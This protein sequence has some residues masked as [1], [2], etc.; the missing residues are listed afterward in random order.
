MKKSTPIALAAILAASVASADMASY[1][2]LEYIETTGAQYI[3][4]GLYPSRTLR[5]V[6]TLSTTDT[7][8]DKM[9]FGVRNAGYAFLCWLGKNPGTK[10]Y[11]AI[12]TSGNIANRNS[13]KT[14]GEKWT[15]DMGAN[16]LYVDGT[17]IF[18]AEEFANYTSTATVSSKT[19]LLFGLSNNG[20]V[21][22]RKYV[23]KCYSFKA[24]DGG[25]L[26]RDLVPARRKSDSVVGLYDRANDV[27]YVNK[28]SGSF[29]AGPLLASSLMVEGSP[30]AVGAV[31]P[32]YGS[33]ANTMITDV[34]TNCSA[35]ATVT[36]EGLTASCAGYRFYRQTGLS[37]WTLES[38][39][40]GNTFTFTPNSQDAR[41]VWLW[42]IVADLA[43]AFDGAPVP[44]LNAI[45]FP[46]SVGGLGASGAPAD[47]KAAWGYVADDLAYT[48]TIATI[49]QIGATSVTLPRLHPG[50]AFFVKLIL[51]SQAA[52]GGSV[53]TGV[54]CVET[55][56]LDENPLIPGLWQTFFTSADKN[57]T[58]DIWAVPEGTDWKNYSDANRIRR[59]E[60][61]VI[62]PYTHGAAPSS[63]TKYLSEVWGDEVWWPVNGGQ[64]AYAGYIWLDAAKS[65][66]F[67][68]KIDDNERIQIT[69]ARTGVTTTLINDTGNGNG[70]NT[71]PV[72]TPSVTGWHAIEL[73][74]SDGSGGLGGYDSAN[75]YV[76][77]S[78]LGFSQD[79][80]A[81]WN[82]L[83]DPGN[84]SLLRAE[85]GD[86]SIFA[87]EMM[88]NGALASVSLDFE[89]DGSANR[90][91]MAAW[92]KVVGGDN[93][94]DWACTGIVATVSATDTNYVWTVPADWGSDSNLVV[95]FYFD[96][97]TVKWS[98]T[99]LWRDYAAPNVTDVVP[100]GTGGDTLVISG[101]LV[102][103]SGQD[104][105][106][107]VHVGESPSTMT[108][109]WT[110]LAGSVRNATG[111]FALT[112][113]ESD[114]A[115]PMYLVPGGTY[116]VAVEA[117]AGGRSSRTATQAVTM[118]AAPVFTASPAAVARRTITFSGVLSD[119]G[120][121]DRATLQLYVGAASDAEE[122]LV[123][124]EEPV[125][126]TGAM[127]FAIAHTFPEFETTYKWQLR[128]VAKAAGETATL[129]TRSPVQTCQ[130]L[131]TTTY[132]WKS[133]VASGAWDDASN[134]TDNQS[135]DCLGYPQ[136]AA[137][138][139]TFPQS[140]GTEV[141]F[142][143]ALS[144]GT[145]QVNASANVTFTQGGA[146]TN[147][148][149][150]TVTTLNLNYEKGSLTLDG[151]AVNAAND[152]TLGLRRALRAINGADLY[153]RNFVQTG[154]N[155]V[156]VAGESVL[157]CNDM[158]F[159]GGTF[160]ISNATVNVRAW[161]YLGDS[162]P[163]GHIVFR[164]DH[165]LFR[166]SNSAGVIYASLAT[167]AVQFD[168]CVPAG[169]YAAAP[170]G[171]SVA[172]T[173]YLGNNKGSAGA[174]SYTVNVLDDSPANF[175]D[176]PVTATLISWPYGINTALVNEGHLPEDN[177]AATDDAFVWG[178]GTYPPTLSVAINGSSHAGEL[179]VSCL[180]AHVDC[181]LLSPSRG[182]HEIAHG[183]LINCSAPADYIML[184]PS[185]RAICVGWK[186]YDIDNA[187]LSRTLAASG[188]NTSC[189]VSDT[190]LWRELE[191]QWRIEHLITAAAGA[192]GSVNPASQWVG[193]GTYAVVTATPDAT[194]GFH[195]WTDGVPPGCQAV[196]ETLHFLVTGPVVVG[197]SFGGVYY[198]SPT[199]DATAPTA[200][201]ATG[202]R[203]IQAAL[204]V[205]RDGDTVLVDAGDYA[206]EDAVSITH[207]VKVIGAGAGLT[208]IFKRGSAE[209]SYRLAYLNHADAVLRGMS[210][211]NG[212]AKGLTGS[213][214]YIDTAGGRV[215]DCYIANNRCNYVMSSAGS[216]SRC[217]F[218][219][220][221]G[222]YNYPVYVKDG[223]IENCLSIRNNV[224]SGNVP[225]VGLR[226]EGKATARNCTVVR[227]S[228]TSTTIGGVCCAAATVRVV[229][230]VIY[231]NTA[232]SS[233]AVGAPDWS[234]DI[235]CFVNCAMQVAPNASCHGGD[236]GFIDAAASNYRLLVGSALRNAGAELADIGALDL[237]GGARISGGA[238][239]I[240]CYEYDESVAAVGLSIAPES[241][242]A[243]D[244]VVFTPAL[245]GIAD[246][247]ART[248]TITDEHGV[249]TV[250]PASCES[251]AVLSTPGLYTVRLDVAVPGG[252]TLSAEREAYLYAGPRTIYVDTTSSTP[253]SPFGTP[254]TAATDVNAAV[255]YAGLK[256]GTEVLVADGDYVLTNQLAMPC[257]MTLH[258]VGGATNTTLRRVGALESGARF[259]IIYMN[260]PGAKVSGFTITGGSISANGG[261]VYI[262]VLGG[263]V[264]D[265]IVS[266]NFSS[267][268]GA[269]GAGIY[270][271]SSAAHVDRCISTSNTNK[272]NGSTCRGA[273][274][275]VG[276]GLLE[277]SLATHNW[278]QHHGAGVYVSGS[279]KVYNCTIYGNTAAG[280]VG[281]GICGNGSSITVRNTASYANA[282]PQDASVGA[283]DIS[284]DGT[285]NYNRFF[286]CAFPKAVGTIE[287]VED[288]AFTDPEGGDFTLQ[289]SSALRNGG[290]AFDGLGAFDLVGNA[291]QSEGT[292][293]DIGCYEYD[294]TQRSIAFT[295]S[296]TV[297]FTGTAIALSP[298]IEGY[299]AGATHAWT[300]TDGNGRVT[301]VSAAEEA[302]F[303]IATAG[304]Y[305]VTLTVSANGAD[306]PVSRE[307]YVRVLD[308]HYSVSNVTELVSAV[309]CASYI[310][311][312][313]IDVADGDYILDDTITIETATT[314]RSANGPG[315]AIL[316]RVG[317]L[318]S[319]NRFR[320]LYINDPNA[321]VSGFTITGGSIS[322][323]GGGVLIGP[324]GGEL[325]Y[326]VVSNN[327]SSNWGASGAGVYM[328]SSAAHV[329]R[330]VSTCNTNKNSGTY[331]CGAGF[332][333]ARGL[334]ENSLA[335]RNLTQH[336]GAGIYVS[337]SGKVYNCT[338]YGNTTVNGPGGGVC[339]TGSSITVVNTAAYGNIAP[340]DTT[341]GAPD[342]GYHD[343]ENYARYSNCAFPA[344]VGNLESI[345]DP[346]FTDAEGGDFTLQAGSPLIDAGAAISGLGPRDLAGNDR[347]YGETVP[348][349]G[350]F[351]Y[352]P[353]QA[354]VSLSVS[355]S[356]GFAGDTFTFTPAIDGIEGELTKTWTITDAS[357]V[358][359]VLDP[360]CEEG[361][362]IS[363][364]GTFDVTLTVSAGG[365]SYSMTRAAIFRVVPRELYV[366]A[367][368][369][370]PVAPYATRA[371]AATNVA[372]AVAEAVDGATI[373]VAPGDYHQSATINLEADIALVSDAGAARTIL[374]R[375][376][377]AG[378]PAFGIVSMNA[379]GAL[380]K[381]FTITGGR[382]G[383]FGGCRI[384]SRGGTL[385]DCVVEDN[386]STS[387][388][389]YYPGGVLASSSRALIR[390]C[391]I[392]NNTMGCTSGQYGAGAAINSGRIE[393]CLIVG[394]AA[395]ASGKCG[396]GLY[397][398][399]TAWNCT[400][401]SN[402]AK[403]V[404]G[405]VQL[406]SSGRC[407]NCAILGNV[408]VDSAQ[409]NQDWSADMREYLT[410]CATPI[411]TGEGYVL[412]AFDGALF[413]NPAAG[414]YTVRNASP[415]I[416]A[417]SDLSYAA[418]DTD[419]AGN[420]RIHEM[421]VN[422]HAA[423]DIGCYEARFNPGGGTVL[424]LQ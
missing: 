114:A 295:A 95:R 304:L 271:N 370:N 41:I 266:N 55:E 338:A 121:C 327:Y 411:R 414:D 254:A 342:V 334:L 52:G 88:Q 90:T 196:D 28:G 274:F 27:F 264:T 310:D 67:R 369:A 125:V 42:S 332:H 186:L 223:L 210:I 226:L 100:D 249:A 347:A 397:L 213:G 101:D 57:W 358:S 373:H 180:P 152:V 405:G 260:D 25:D 356:V 10:V 372:D 256:A 396:G 344:A 321:K 89:A 50:T 350:C 133:S 109:A 379:P 263:E 359:T 404:T 241:V 143:R 275:F 401:V 184:T 168:F 188:T 326:S 296:P 374:R 162:K 29:I 53:E 78:N 322:A 259:R 124:V 171:S 65:Y 61:T 127:Q 134:W 382:G 32:A 108:N 298:T 250:L 104:C 207:G 316:R 111:A 315:G 153:T 159:G 303:S 214:V 222:S 3:D 375:T 91:L 102:S 280:G 420:P 307:D 325:S 135:G 75:N 227:N 15:L 221:T 45:S 147:D 14:S 371:T 194:H 285:A 80:G 87:T 387:S 417:G 297:L 415:L 413:R 335:T 60:T 216:V 190:G 360:G 317:P 224:S 255:F 389:G 36:A 40:A 267:C 205:A 158:R 183:G 212:L 195:K 84:G 244:T 92:G 118:K 166:H 328:N 146:S 185:N 281:G 242:F 85:M 257:A 131:D 324:R 97:T 181:N 270:M 282:A 51:E 77:T 119:P 345:P 209:V 141:L 145:L 179:L 34:A 391:I 357:G 228:T 355:P 76:N 165:P 199:G 206:L 416:N 24:Y 353:G 239:D 292:V 193:E 380:V 202:Y 142:R 19:L 348:D 378:S 174:G 346:L 268:W 313:E 258:S 160:T 132:T 201:Y 122:T 235:N 197:A 394:N 308:Q 107:T 288:P 419:L 333:V 74:F 105:V 272:N 7:G 403:R 189:A 64:W 215:E 13:G 140:D 149:K 58:K 320:I 129:E 273:G 287:A 398:N 365:Q 62:A 178:D 68:T 252:Q 155:D 408:L 44:S 144:V 366:D 11:P 284:P 106:L 305:T 329:D 283:P 18:T 23:G 409:E 293:P 248:W 318:E 117:A 35:P 83:M 286:N 243:G 238:I 311:G 177:G 17:A 164:G 211:T 113:F 115:S 385:E 37:E 337:G 323:N 96:G 157:N 203:T 289:A 383:S 182:Y 277:N 63:C 240:G 309:D 204:A 279:G 352:Q 43:I 112:L 361:V 200:G 170:F 278:T 245:V 167:S 137:A 56:A 220:N 12:G 306:Y 70:V 237:D 386:L 116:Y 139:A 47:V 98:N 225:G 349:I 229:N 150:L 156:L 120:M 412:T 94:A 175:S 423:C 319:G 198:V 30:F 46:I 86:I 393:N 340:Y 169:G 300:L 1:S 103:F 218:D 49:S 422:R 208:T 128:A 38:S 8:T 93:P 21:D 301:H 421:G 402:T 230:C 69:D 265:C 73:R 233:T 82:L 110:G 253:R 291:R 368:S 299:G 343:G 261:G 173:Y 81:T 251:G 31:S 410:Y 395:T 276:G 388:Y 187:T 16:G 367:A 154:S 381:G 339:G 424:I 79:G 354:A 407:V 376:F 314:L 191:W 33:H 217:V 336:R 138:T 231:D 5:V 72:Y 219:G 4:T 312:V 22:G 192:G 123:A 362:A 330:C 363:A 20:S 9:T 39:G 172:N 66:K 418:G 161:S 176:T 59:R 331:C 163:G 234:G 351:E 54:V 2:F 232:S 390:R 26:V 136:T 148:T 400:V 302:A 269:T 126:A 6:E 236:G 71:S 262:D 384:E 364:Y 130:T 392:R 294:E 48:N 247:A 406:G 99:I 341:A 151:V 399:G 377:G 246:D 290:A